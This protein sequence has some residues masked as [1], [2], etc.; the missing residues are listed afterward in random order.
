M[1]K[2][3]QPTTKSMRYSCGP[4]A[5]VI[6]D[7]PGFGDGMTNEGTFEDQNAMPQAKSVW[8]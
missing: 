7:K 8:E 4:F 6:S 5:L 1:K 2:Y 3:I